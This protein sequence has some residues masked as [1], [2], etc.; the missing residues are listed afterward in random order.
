MSPVGESG[1]STNTVNMTI[2]KKIIGDHNGKNIWLYTLSNTK[3]VTAKV[4]NY[5]GIL[6]EL[7][8]PGREG[9]PA[10]I[11]LGFN[12]LEGYLGEHPY[13]G[14]LIGRYANRIAKGEFTL[15]GNKYT[16]AR[17]NG[18]NH[19]HGGLRG[20]DKV[21]WDIL[22]VTAEGEVG[23]MLKYTSGDGEE[24]YPG[25]L[26][27]NVTYIVTNENELR[28]EYEAECSRPTPVNLTHH[29]YFNLKGAGNGD[30]LDHILEINA[31][32]FT[33]VNEE[34]I[35]TGE[36]RD[37]AE[38]P[39]DFR[40]GK[41]IGRDIA[42]VPGAYDHN[43]VL[44]DHGSLRKVAEVWEE[45]S[46]RIMK[47][48]TTEPGL[49]FYSGNFLDGSLTGK[50]DSVYYKHYGF[51]L[52]AQHYPD[53]PNNPEFPDVILEPGERYHQVTVYQFATF[54]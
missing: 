34:L 32:K 28:I 10:D 47:V 43:F 25:T 49:Q 7:H 33:V 39:F 18:N 35:P 19:L 26:W 36:L 8:V 1:N 21:V 11:V 17:N 3:G 22:E 30:I 4:M 51:C 37:V 24:G 53:S 5:G 45:S 23:V 46:G 15:E 54:E 9:Q 2:E 16:L 12:D 29:S 40:N 38:T 14:A 44:N 31:R 48:F 52:E 42:R 20:F 6:T 27:V 50:F 41:K 13:F